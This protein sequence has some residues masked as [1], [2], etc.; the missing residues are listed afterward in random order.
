MNL[1]QRLVLGQVKV[2][3]QSNGVFTMPSSA[4]I[5]YGRPLGEWVED[6][7]AEGTENTHYF[8]REEAVLP[9]ADSPDF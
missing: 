5:T 1:R 9:T 8:P 7:H 2:A 3:D 4:T 6:V